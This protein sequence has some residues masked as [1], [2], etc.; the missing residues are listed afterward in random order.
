MLHITGGGLLLS[1]IISGFMIFSS[2]HPASTACSKPSPT[3]AG[4][5]EQLLRGPINGKWYHGDYGQSVKLPNG[6]LMW[7]FG[8]TFIATAGATRSNLLINNTAL[9]TEKGCITALTGPV[10]NEKETSWIKP[11]GTN[12]IPNQEDYYWPST[13]F[14]DGSTLRMFL[15]HMYNDANGFHV[16][17]VDLATLNTSGAQP[18]VSSVIKTSASAAGDTTPLWGAATVASGGYNYIFGSLNKHELWVFGKYYY[19]ARVPV[20][21]TTNS[22]SWRYWNGSAWVKDATAATPI[23]NGSVGL[24]TNVNVY[25]KSNGEFVIINKKYDP[26]G[27]DLVALK[28]RT[29]TGPWTELTPPLIAPIPLPTP[30]ISPRDHTYLGIGHPWVPLASGKLLVNWSLNFEGWDAFGDHRYGIYF[31]EVPQP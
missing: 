29:I 14:M 9:L 5:W 20:G 16:I 8:D 15:L 27:T 26:F 10:V 17:G 31:S 30:S 24:A 21:Q 12:D 1:L 7:V 4:A 22:A 11:T 3:T 18:K 2:A 19:L 6:K 25:K 13:P 28:T 23:I